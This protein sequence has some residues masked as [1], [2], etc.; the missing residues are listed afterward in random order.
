MCCPDVEVKGGKAIP[1]YNFQLAQ[2][3]MTLGNPLR[4][5]RPVNPT[6]V[7]GTERQER[8]RRPSTL[9]PCFRFHFDMTPPWL[10]WRPKHAAVCVG[11]ALVDMTRSTVHRRSGRFRVRVLHLVSTFPFQFSARVL[12]CR[13][14]RTEEPASS[15]SCGCLMTRRCVR[16]LAAAVWIAVAVVWGVI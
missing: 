11:P 9:L 12:Y 4:G 3:T 7:I 16:V 8:S 1:G 5:R 10:E 13:C 15:L 2:H 6:S 14:R